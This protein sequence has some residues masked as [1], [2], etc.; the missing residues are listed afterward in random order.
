[1]STQTPLEKRVLKA[2]WDADERV[3]ALNAA[4]EE[5]VSG[6]TLPFGPHAMTAAI[7]FASAWVRENGPLP[8]SGLICD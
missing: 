7:K 2:K 6:S 4:V 8:E 1:M 3:I 5:H